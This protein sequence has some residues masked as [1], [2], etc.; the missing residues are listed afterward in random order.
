MLGMT[1]ASPNTASFSSEAGLQ[2]TTRVLAK[3]AL[4]GELIG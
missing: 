4:W 1:K 3:A 2:E